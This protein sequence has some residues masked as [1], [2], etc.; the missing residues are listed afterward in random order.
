MRIRS[1]DTGARQ[2][3][4]AAGPAWMTETIVPIPVAASARA[5]VLID[6]KPYAGFDSMQ[7][8]EEFINLATGVIDGNGRKVTKKNGVH[9][10]AITGKQIVAVTA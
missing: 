9:W 2:I 10:P 3:E 6:G 5:V 7:A 1:E 4:Y 8:A